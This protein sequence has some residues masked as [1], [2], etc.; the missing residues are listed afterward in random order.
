MTVT[1]LVDTGS[2]LTFI[3]SDEYARL[4]SPPLGGCRHKVKGFG[5]ADNETWGEFTKV[6]MVDGYAFTVT[7]HVVSNKVLREHSLLLDTDFFGSDRVAGQT[8]RGE[9]FT[10]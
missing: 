7:L 9:L 10:I 3:R 5:S 2:E 8:G 6:T 1:S 4:G